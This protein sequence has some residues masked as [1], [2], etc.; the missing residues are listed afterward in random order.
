[1]GCGV[2]S[3]GGLTSSPPQVGGDFAFADSDLSLTFPEGGGAAV[4]VLGSL[5]PT[6]ETGFARFRLGQMSPGLGTPVGVLGPG[7]CWLLCCGPAQI[8]GPPGFALL[9]PLV[10]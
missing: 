8:W 6:V 1:M 7:K 10:A 3:R 4:P 5:L 9:Q 2:P